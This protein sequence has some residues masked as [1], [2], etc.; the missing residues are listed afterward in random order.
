MFNFTDY[1][2]P[3]W[4]FISLAI[5]LF[6][7]RILAPKKNIVVKEVNLNNHQDLVFRKKDD[8]CYKYTKK[9]TQCTTSK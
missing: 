4:F 5:T 3:L 6:L 2:S 8:S 7:V 1:I 9:E